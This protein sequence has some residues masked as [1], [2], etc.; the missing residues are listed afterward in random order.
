MDA[1]DELKSLLC[2]LR[3]ENRTDHQEIKTALNALNDR[4]RQNEVGLAH[5]DGLPDRVQQNEVDI[6][7]VRERQGVLAV[8]SGAAGAI[9]GIVAPWLGIRP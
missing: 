3:A 6:A 5:V 4:V 9:A 1:P 2:D 8:V 7:R